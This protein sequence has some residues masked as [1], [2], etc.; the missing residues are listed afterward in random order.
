MVSASAAVLITA[1]STPTSYCSIQFWLATLGLATVEAMLLADAWSTFYRPW[2]SPD[3]SKLVL[4]FA[5]H[6][7]LAAGVAATTQATG[8]FAPVNWLTSVTQF[9]ISCQANVVSGT[10]STIWWASQVG[11]AVLI[12][13]LRFKSGAA[14]TGLL[15]SL[16]CPTALVVGVLG[17]AHSYHDQVGA[18]VIDSK[19]LSKEHFLIQAKGT[20]FL[21]RAKDSADADLW[22]HD[23]ESTFRDGDSTATSQSAANNTNT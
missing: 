1:S 22:I 13:V 9:S 5:V 8:G 21:V 7:F 6:V 11:V 20:S 18:A 19:L 3:D 12:G 4:V 15:W 17:M 2:K 16:V 23:I 14:T 10:I